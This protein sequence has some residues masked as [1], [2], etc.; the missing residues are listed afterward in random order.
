MMN[1]ELASYYNTPGAED[2]EKQA[3]VENFAKLA[4]KH[5]IDLTQMDNNEVDALYAEVY[6]EFSKTAEEEDDE[7]EDE[8]EDKK[9]SASYH[10]Q[11]KLSFQEKTAEADFMGRVM[12]HSF[13]QELDNI[14]KVAVEA[15][16]G[17]P[18][19]ASR[20]AQDVAARQKRKG[21]GGGA[22]LG[23]TG[24][25]VSG[26]DALKAGQGKKDYASM[27]SRLKSY[28]RRAVKAI[29]NNP[30]RAAAAG[31]GLAAATGGAAYLAGKKKKA[32]ADFEELAANHAIKIA[33]ASGYDEDQA[34]QLVSSV[35][36][37]GLEE[38][39]KV[40]Y[41]QDFDDALHVR[42]LE[43]LETAGYDVDWSEVFG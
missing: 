22:T 18:R 34:L 21:G 28:R 10:F 36:N 1:A 23:S 4:A 26:A 29:G 3:S 30:G 19:S 41:V 33:S 31:L 27:G 11:E 20:L 8:D 5:G 32:S 2:L 43:Y 25:T 7:D 17:T 40:A 15:Q 16:P 14:E 39:E 13:T 6:P 35:Y 37:L 24:R 12:A 42:G 38:T 9:K